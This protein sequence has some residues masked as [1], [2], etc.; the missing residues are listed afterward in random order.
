MRKDYFS[1]LEAVE[2]SPEVLGLVQIN[3]TEH[4]GAEKHLEF[5]KSVM[6]GGIDIKSRPP[7]FLKRFTHSID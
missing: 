5:L 2:H 4:P 1:V 3:S 6:G 7:E